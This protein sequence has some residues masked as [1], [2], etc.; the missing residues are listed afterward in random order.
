MDVSSCQF[1]DL[2][3]V[4]SID[5]DTCPRVASGRLELRWTSSYSLARKRNYPRIDGGTS[6]QTIDRPFLRRRL[7]KIR[8]GVTH[9]APHSLRMGDTGFEPVTSTV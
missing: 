1:H 4:D 5:P 3:F 9:S 2:P 8:R 7:N 6:H